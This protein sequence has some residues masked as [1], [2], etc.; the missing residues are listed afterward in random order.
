MSIISSQFIT[1]FPTIL[2]VLLLVLTGLFSWRWLSTYLR[3]EN[4]P[5]GPVPL[6]VIGSLHLLGSL[7][8]RSLHKLSQKYGPIMSIRLGSVQFVIVSSPDAA[9]LFLGTHD[10]VFAS[11]PQIQAAKYLS[12]DNK[13]MTFS[14]YG[15]YW[16][17]V[18]K[19]CTVELL[20]ATKINGFAGMRREEIGLMVEEMKAAA[21]VRKMVNL[22]EMV[23]SVIEGMVC[24]MLF[25][26]KNDDRFAFKTVIDKSMEATGIFNLADYV[27]ML[28][29]FDLQFGVGRR[30]CP[31]MNLGLLNIGLVV[32]NLVHLFDWELPNDMSPSD[33][34]MEEKFGLTTPR[35]LPLL[36][37]C[38]FFYRW[39]SRHN[40]LP[41]GPSPLPVIGSLHLLGSLPHR[42]FHKLSQKYGPI[43]SIR[44]GSVQFVIV[45]SPDAAKLFLGT[46][47]IVFAS[48]PQTEAAK[49]LS[50]DHKGMAFTEYGPYWR[51]VRKFC[52]VE[53]L[54]A[55][56]I[57]SYAWMRR[58]EIGLMVEEMKAA[59]KVRKE[60]NL[61]KTVSLVMEGMVCR[62]LFG[63]KN[64][65]RF[66]FK[67]VLNKCVEALGTF[68]LAD[69]VPILAPFDLQGLSKRSKSLGKELDEMLEILIDEHERNQTLKSQNRDQMDFIDTLL[70]LKKEY[71]NAHD[72]L[73][74]TIDRTNMKAILVDMV[75]GAIDTGT[76]S[77][78]WVLSV[79][80]KHPRVMKELQQEL[81]TIVG[82]KQIVEE[83]NLTKLKY[84][85]MVVKETFR[86]YPVVPLLVPHQSVED[87]VINGYNIP[88]K[89]RVLVN[90]WAFGRD[91][92]VWSEN[93]EEFLPE[94]FLDK[95]IDFRGQDFKLIQFG[96]GRRGCPGMNLGLLNIGLVVANMVHWFNWE[97][98]NGMSPSD[99]D[100]NEKLGITTARAK[101]LIAIPTYRT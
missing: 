8:H 55:S 79:L 35:L 27:P 91:P 68:N 53:L 36:F 17:S 32:S 30:G 95:E 29:P 73:S 37:T 41:P 56:K 20:S 40:N 85:H 80:I 72:E 6:P 51:S 89:T 43:M 75:A 70:S 52:A 54:S 39:W 44:L 38:I 84:L 10:T 7:P 63:K 99:L 16:R 98:P 62:M 45:S 61:S 22:S 83:D 97:L 11:R 87:I 2:E 76:T 9:K 24:R 59:A 5:P 57:N 21:K 47:D 96:V 34:D 101:P 60:I 25:G 28:A 90:Y 78:E 26:K 93:W 86:L 23:S 15:P 4:L 50:Y 88:N 18:R 77:I 3:R 82:D 74:Y 46:H 67:S 48:R 65:D 66:V 58:E 42:S 14:E 100:M 33:L 69:Y 12:Y 64:D 71:S 31:G 94:R 1:M 13:G 49:Y 81:K 92:N 19:F